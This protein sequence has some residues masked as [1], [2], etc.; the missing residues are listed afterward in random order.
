VKVEQLMPQISVDPLKRSAD[1]LLNDE[2]E[3]VRKQVSPV[4]GGN[5]PRALQDVLNVIGD[6]LMS[7]QAPAMASYVAGKVYQRLE[8]R[9]TVPELFG[10]SQPPEHL[11]LAVSNGLKSLPRL[12]SVTEQLPALIERLSWRGGRGGPYASLNFEKAH[13]HAVV[14][15]PGGLEERSDVRLGLTLMAPYSR[16]PDH[17]QFHSRVFLLISDGE[18]SLDDSNWFRA[19]AGEIFFNEAG[20][21][22]AMRCTADPLLAVWCHVEDASL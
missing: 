22:F 3:P 8:R 20:R 5:R 6:M 14:V 4:T 2:H 10:K 1:I 16:F 12:A 17:V 7:P 15:G 21:K 13:A 19:G 11:D 18:V 9:G